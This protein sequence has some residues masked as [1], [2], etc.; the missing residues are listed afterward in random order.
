MD[1]SPSLAAFVRSQPV[2]RLATADSYGQPHVVPICFV[3]ENGSFFIAIDEKPKRTIRLKR[4]QN[5]EENPHVALVMD[6]YHDDWSR[7]AWVMVQGIATIHENAKGQPA[8]LAALRNK[9]PQYR[10]MVLE[11]RPMIQ[12]VPEHIMSWGQFA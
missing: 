6:V 3:Y 7:I 10:S 9:Y 5:I 4:L 1:L 11:S 12:V 2:A 8:I